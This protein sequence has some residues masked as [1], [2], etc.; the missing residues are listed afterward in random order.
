MSEP[1]A[2]AKS[3][4][5]KN[6]LLYT[7]ARLAL[8][9]VLAAVIFFAPKAVG[10]AVPLLVAM[11]FGLLVSLPISMFAFKSLRLAVNADIAAVDTKRREQRADLEAQL[12]GDRD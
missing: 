1:A 11:A 2:G 9:A 7:L 12:R 5:I 3:S 8:F 6:L 10:V 4:L